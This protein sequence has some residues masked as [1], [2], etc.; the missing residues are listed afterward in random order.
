M[1]H[2]VYQYLERKYGLNARSVHWEPDVQ[3]DDTMI[4]ELRE[5]L[6]NHPAR[7]MIWESEPRPESAALLTGLGL[8]SAVF[9]PCGNRPE[10]GDYLTVM[11]RNAEELRRVLGP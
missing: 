7:W 10:A 4:D 9:N 5:V 6:S 2:P 1:S 8:R 3:P 11:Q